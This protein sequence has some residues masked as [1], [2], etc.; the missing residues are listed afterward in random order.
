MSRAMMKIS[1]QCVAAIHTTP[2]RVGAY[3][4]RRMAN[5][6]LNAISGIATV[7]SAPLDSM[8]PT[9]VYYSARRAA[10]VTCRPRGDPF[11]EVSLSLAAPV[12][13]PSGKLAVTR[14]GWAD[15]YTRRGWR[16]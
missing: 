3:D 7:R 12:G 4:R 10:P 9:R 13:T 8:G 2:S 5:Q 16:S 6:T 11:G 1:G 15:G 14:A